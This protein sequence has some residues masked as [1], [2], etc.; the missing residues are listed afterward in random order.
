MIVTVEELG[1][2]SLY[3]E[4]IKTITRGDAAA[5]ELQILA[6]EDMARSYLF[7]YDLKAAFGDG[8]VPPTVVSPLLQKI[9]KMIASYFLV[10]MA[11]PNVN[12]Q[13]YRDDYEH[14][15]SLLEDIRDGRNNISL[16]YAPDD[17]D[18][19]EDEGANSMSWKSEPKRTNYF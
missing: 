11:N 12:L 10:R 13:L 3:P 4:V 5:A 7:K 19:P 9:V 18:T 2:T 1:K 6:A 17:P 15:I 16:P 14:A 8:G